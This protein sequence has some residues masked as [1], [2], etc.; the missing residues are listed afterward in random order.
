[1][2]VL[3]CLG[4]LSLLGTQAYSQSTFTI[5]GNLRDSASVE[6]LIGANVFDQTHRQGTAANTYGFYSLTLP[7]GEVS[8]LYSYVGYQPKTFGF[9]LDKDTVINIRLSDGNVLNEVVITGNS[10]AIQEMTRMSTIEVPV[11]QIKTLPALMGE[12]DVIKTLQLLP[13]V[14][15]GTEGSAGIYVR[16]GGPDQNLIL[17]DGVPVYN[18][19]HLFGFFSVFNADAINHVELIKGGFP[20]RYGGRLSSVIDI[21]MKEGNMNEFKGEGSIGII[22]SKLTLEGPIWKDKT[23]FI[24]SGRRTYID[25]LAQPF[26]ALANRDD[27]NTQSNVGYFFHDV[28]AKL[29]H[30]FSDKNRVFLSVYTGLDRF[31]LNNK[32]RYE[33]DPVFDPESF[34]QEQETEAGID[35][36][37]VTAALRWN[38]ILTQKLFMNTSVTFSDYDFNIGIGDN[39]RTFLTDST[40]E[41]FFNLEYVSGIR[42]WTGRVDFDYLPS[43][44]H[45][46]RF[47]ASVIYHTFSP[48]ANTFQTSFDLDTT[49]G[50]PEVYAYEYAVFAEDD[51]KI[52]DLLKV[53]AGVHYASFAVE[54][55]YYQSVQPRIAARYLVGQ[56]T[57]IKA[58]YASMAQFIHLLTNAGIGL[59]TDLW[60]PSTARVRPQTAQQVAVG[61]AHTLPNDVEVSVEGYYK[62]MQNLIEYGDGASFLNSGTDWQDKIE[63]GD[64]ESYGA[65]LFL[66][67]NVGPVTGWIGYTLSWTNRTFPELNLGRTFPYRYDRRHD[68]SIVLVSNFWKYT[69]LSATWV[70]GTGNSVTLP[71]AEYPTAQFD[72]FIP[73]DY[74]QYSTAAYVEGRNGYRMP[75]YH[76]LDVSATF[77]LPVKGGWDGSLIVG[78]YNA[79]NRKNPF[80]IDEG[81]NP[82]TGETSFYAYALFPIIPSVSLRFSF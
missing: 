15:S 74:Y 65:E 5:S 43:P 21:S 17:L 9:T 25:I 2:R 22:S 57:S 39:T 46:I 52:T 41:E 3:F 27:P 72:P 79:Y 64:G 11:A 35:W 44:D 53:N 80:F 54:G 13:G 38:S 59:P 60:V 63:I 50:A 62:R 58:S 73:R 68:L 77:T 70:Y 56:N 19:N 6:A 12:V 76:R 34:P 20:A 49:I 30:R 66:Q 37:N 14:Q 75:A 69:T 48:G 33:P 4:L 7:A 40:V 61:V 32:F 10:E 42:D 71:N 36:G 8:L 67:R 55:E 23:S 51:W 1:M 29:N 82:D 78:A 31:Y 16:G 81:L 28:N 45:Y 47:G 26:I 18:A 24:V